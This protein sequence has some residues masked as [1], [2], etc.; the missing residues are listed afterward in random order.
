MLLEMLE[1]GI[2][3]QIRFTLIL[4]TL[5]LPI[6]FVAC[7]GEEVVE[8]I[9]ASDDPEFAGLVDVDHNTDWEVGQEGGRLVLS[10]TSDPKTFNNIVADET[11]TTDITERLIAYP[12]RRNQFSLVWE[13]WLAEW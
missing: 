3:K 13:P 10:S 6:L 4:V 9:E 11:S 8:D 5:L 7:G 2:V 12:V 1:G